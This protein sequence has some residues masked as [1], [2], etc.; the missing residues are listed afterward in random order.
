MWDESTVLMLLQG[1]GESL[2]MTLLSTL[3][4]Y[5]IGLPVGIFLVTSSKDGLHPCTGLFKTLDV[6]V[7]LTRS[8]PFLILLVAIIPFTRLVTG[9]IIGSTATVVP[10]TLSAAP[11][12]ARLVESSLKEV[13]AGVVEAAQSMGASNVQIVWKVLLPEARPSLLVGCAIAVTTVLGYSA[14]AGFV[15]GG[16]LGTIAI[17]Y[18]YYRYQ[19]GIMLMTVVLLVLIVQVFQGFGMKMAASFDRRK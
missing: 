18:G 13:D 10:L 9:T 6:I 4:A 2:Y 11:F 15:G 1:I 8:V 14:M 16:G 3:F 12:V 19:N 5:M 7:N 17:N